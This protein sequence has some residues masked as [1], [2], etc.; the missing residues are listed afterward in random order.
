MQ[1]AD[2]FFV[3]PF[4]EN[5]VYGYLLAAEAVVIFGGFIACRYVGGQF[6]TLLKRDSA[7]KDLPEEEFAEKNGAKNAFQSH[8][9]DG[10]RCQV[11]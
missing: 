11:R 4:R 2:Q 7:E 10:W 1:L 5:P 3:A 6:D 9:F 8:G